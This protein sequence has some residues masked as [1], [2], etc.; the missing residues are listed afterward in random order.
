MKNLFAIM[1]AVSLI[2]TLCSCGEK[3][4]KKSNRKPA[5]S[6]TSTEVDETVTPETESP[7]T[8]PSETEPNPDDTGSA[9]DNSPKN[10]VVDSNIPNNEPPQNEP[11]IPINF[12]P[13]SIPALGSNEAFIA[14]FNEVYYKGVK[15]AG[16]HGKNN[17][18][19]CTAIVTVGDNGEYLNCISVFNSANNEQAVFTV[20]NDRIYYLQYVMNDPRT[21]TLLN[22][23]SVYSMNLLGK[24]KRLEKKIDLTFTHIN[25]YSFYSD[26]KYMFFMVDDLINGKYSILHRYN[27]ETKEFVS[28]NQNFGSHKTLFSV[29]EKV[30]VYSSDDKAVYQYDIGFNNKN[31]FF[32]ASNYNWSSFAGNGLYFS[33]INNK[34]KH[35]VSFS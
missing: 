11:Q 35:F 8:T 6:S 20:Y 12:V 7:D 23:F 18:V 30:F 5:N 22:S 13:Q 27:T 2:F 31:L 21:A 34:N 25:C 17:G 14:Y 19:D 16:V 1:M 4:N 15:Y 9:V 10:E 28:L 24:D 3:D 26:S 33:E 32:N 29:N